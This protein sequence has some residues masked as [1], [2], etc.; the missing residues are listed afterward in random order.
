MAT[1][2][3][4]SPGDELLIKLQTKKLSD[5]AR[6]IQEACFVLKANGL[7]TITDEK[8]LV[9]ASGNILHVKRVIQ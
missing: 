5:A 7:I 2:E 9:E 6:K 4:K 3:L 1:R 8:I